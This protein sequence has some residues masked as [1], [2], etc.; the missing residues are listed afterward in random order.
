MMVI[1]K[2]KD[3]IYQVL[4][5]KTFPRETQPQCLPIL[6]RD[7]TTDQCTDTTQVKFDEPVSCIGL[8]VKGY[9]EEQE[10]LQD[11]CITKAG[12]SMG[13]CSQKTETS[14]RHCVACRQHNRS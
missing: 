8:R 5:D 14:R 12:P 2:G 13:D 6:H 11:S 4:C 3:G 7:S 9:L 1:G 10:G